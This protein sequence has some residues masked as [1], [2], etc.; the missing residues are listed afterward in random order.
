MTAIPVPRLAVLSSWAHGLLRG[1]LCADGLLDQLD[2]PEFFFAPPFDPA[3]W[4]LDLQLM[5]RPIVNLVLPQPGR[6]AGLI[7]PPPAIAAALGTGQALV[8]ADGPLAHHTLTV[9]RQDPHHRTLVVDRHNAPPNRPVTPQ[10]TDGAREH[11]FRCLQDAADRAQRLDI[12]LE[13]PVGPAELPDDWFLM[14]PHPGI[15]AGHVETARI[16]G[17]AAVQ[18]ERLLEDPDLDTAR[19]E[20][21]RDLHDAARSALSAVLS[22]SPV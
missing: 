12:V 21:V 3:A 6:I 13:E 1:R 7:G 2:G 11:L 17:R 8:V 19:R 20:L 14:E 16:A 9:H 4:L 10:R 15:D 22:S 18:C 5:H